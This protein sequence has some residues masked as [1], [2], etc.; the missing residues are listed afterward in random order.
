MFAEIT[1]ARSWLTLFSALFD[2]G[3]KNTEHYASNVFKLF[4]GI[5]WEMISEEREPVPG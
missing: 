4:G 1:G 3:G 2:V 5:R